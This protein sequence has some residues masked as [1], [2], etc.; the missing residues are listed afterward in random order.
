VTCYVYNNTVY[1]GAVGVYG[2][3]VSNAVSVYVENNIFDTP[4]ARQGSGY[5]TWDYNDNVQANAIGPH[6]MHV[7]PQYVNAGALNFQLQSTSPVIDKGTNVGLPMTGSAP[8]LGAFEYGMAPV[9]ITGSQTNVALASNGGVATASSSYSSAYP[10]SAAN[11]GD[12]KGL[13]WGA[14]GGWNDATTNAW[15]DW[16]EVD[17]NGSKTINEVDVFTLQDN[18]GSP[19]NPTPTMTFSLYGITDFQ[20]QYLSGGNWVTVPGGTVSG[21][22]LVWRQVTFSPL[23]TTGIRVWVTGALAGYSRITEVEAY[24][25][26]NPV[27]TSP[28]QGAIYTAGTT[29]PVTASASS[30]NGISKV[31]FFA[32]GSPIGTATA[33]PYTMSTWAPVVTGSYTLTAVATDTTSATATS[34]P[35]TI[36]VNPGTS[37]TNVA[38]ASNG[39]VVT[40]SSTYSSAYPTSAANDGDRKGLNWGAGGGWNDATTNVWPDW[41]EVDFNGS[42]TINEVDVF[43]LQDNYQ[44]PSDPTPTMTFTLYGVTDFQLQYWTGSAWANVPGGAVSGNNLVWRQVTFSPLTTSSIRVWITGALGGY[45][46][47]TEVEAYTSPVNVALA[48]NG[49]V[50]TASSS[51]S[52]AYPS[53]AANDGDRKGV[54]WGAGGGWNDATANAW[55]DWVEVDFNGLKTI[56]E[57]DV[58]T[59]QDN[60]QSPSD[61]TP[62]MTFTLYG[63]TDFQVQYWTG[64]AWAAV[65]GASVSGNNLVWRQ[66][67]FSPLTTSAIRVWITN[68]P[69]G[70]SRI[71]EVE[72]YT[73]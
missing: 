45:S 39:G 18:Y 32:N 36:T 12:R 28:A 69:A 72:A 9:T 35:V 30:S 63:V 73:Q 15:P 16:L 20:V 19:S 50:T 61:P 3:H 67:M 40:A 56:S 55:P 11:N 23:T 34:A 10:A 41:L 6:D 14:G 43:T 71:T 42:K 48:A 13:N 57:V 7:S 54:N 53:S 58:F 70:Y 60:Y 59:L 1:A 26:A 33:S 4:I 25:P 37:H 2:G 46:R 17:F 44:S 5:V 62:A 8:D 29:I 65:P 27:L 24:T 64:S 21:N 49:G 22:N 66:F 31:D 52:N 47:I 51:Y 68:A 38:L